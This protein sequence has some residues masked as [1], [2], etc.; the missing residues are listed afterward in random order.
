MAKYYE[1]KLVAW[2]MI[3]EDMVNNS[4]EVGE[5]A[6][7]EFRESPNLYPVEVEEIVEEVKNGNL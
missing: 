2:V 3:G 4:D 1:V 7:Q 6:I 5:K